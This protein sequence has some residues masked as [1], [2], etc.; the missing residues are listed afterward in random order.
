MKKIEEYISKNK[1]SFNSLEPSSDHMLN[2]ERKLRGKGSSRVIHLLKPALQIAAIFVLV[3]L[4]SLWVIDNFF[5]SEKTVTGTS[6]SQVSPELKEVEVYY[7]SMIEEKYAELKSIDFSSE[8][9]QKDILLKELE[10]MN[11]IYESLKLELK[12]NPSNENIIN[13]MIQYYQM[14]AE[15]MSQIIEQ[16]KELDSSTTLKSDKN[17]TT[18]I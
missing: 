13:A 10:E 17:E 9:V 16:L 4:S 7:T 6:L 3:A 2:F 14:K 15:V 11:T 18:E 8:E 12:S 1:D 5:A